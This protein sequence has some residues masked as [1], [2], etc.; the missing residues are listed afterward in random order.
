MKRCPTCKRSYADDT[1]RF[2]LE[3]GTELDF[4]P[5][6]PTVVRSGGG[7]PQRTEKFPDAVTQAAR[8]AT[9]VDVPSTQNY[10]PQPAAQPTKS[11]SIVLKILIAIVALAVIVVVAA[12]GLLGLFYYL[13]SRQTTVANIQTATPVPLA[14][15]SGSPYVIALDPNNPNDSLEDKLKEM[16]K[17]LDEAA[18]GNSDSDIPFD[19]NDLPN[20]G[21]TATVNSP[22]DGFL[23]LRNLPST[24]IGSLIAKI[25]H[26]TTIKVMICSEQSV[27]I[28]GRSGHWCMVSY[29]GQTGWV[30]DVW[31][32]FATDSKN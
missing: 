15:P 2:C 20:Y 16:Q 26:G 21:R 10:A 14:S 24:E 1:L 13:G 22:N 7:D 28:A 29:N 6:G 12:A 3:D 5:E 17:K 27:T 32:S 18:N 4:L 30:F 9:R 11:G 19:T 23:A 31:L 8:Q 25:P